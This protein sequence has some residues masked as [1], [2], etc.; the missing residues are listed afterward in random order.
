MVVQEDEFPSSESVVKTDT[1]GLRRDIEK[2]DETKEDKTDHGKISHI[3]E[4]KKTGKKPIKKIK[5]IPYKNP[6]TKKEDLKGDFHSNSFLS[7]INLGFRKLQGIFLEQ[8]TVNN[9]DRVDTSLRHI[10]PIKGQNSVDIIAENN[11]Q[12]G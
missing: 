9:L 7:E 12:I 2:L 6:S 8:V 4:V 10:Q 11:H 5:S 1:G 3:T